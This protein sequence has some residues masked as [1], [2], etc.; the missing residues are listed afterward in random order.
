MRRPLIARA[1]ALLHLVAMQK[2]KSKREIKKDAFV[3]DIRERNPMVAPPSPRDPDERKGPITSPD[4]RVPKFVHQD[5]DVEKVYSEEML[6][7]EDDT[8]CRGS[9]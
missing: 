1:P 3:E 9:D 2:D 8:F 5:G 7:E 6:E 4:G